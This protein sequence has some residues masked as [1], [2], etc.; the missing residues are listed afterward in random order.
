MDIKDIIEMWDDVDNL[1]SDLVIAIAER[2]GNEIKDEEELVTE[3]YGHGIVGDVR[4]NVVAFLKKL[5]YEFFYPDY[6]DEE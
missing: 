5:G 2:A 4:E 6:K 1:I 3:M